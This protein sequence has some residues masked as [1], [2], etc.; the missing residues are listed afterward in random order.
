MLV[1]VHDLAAIDPVPQH[2]IE[3]APS[4]RLAAPAAA[5]RA[6]PGFAANA[7][8]IELL[9]QQSHRAEGGVTPEDMPYHLSFGGDHDQLVV[10][11]PVTEGRHAAHPHALLL[12]GGDLVADA[13]PGDFALELGE[14]QQ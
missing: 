1:L 10:S 5:R 13:L 8:A 6:D 4:E 9:L 2:R 12:R 11:A 7:G 3:R 14:G